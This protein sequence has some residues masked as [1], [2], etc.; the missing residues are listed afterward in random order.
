MDGDNQVGPRV[1]VKMRRR[2]FSVRRYRNAEPVEWVLPPGFYEN[3]AIGVWDES[4]VL[5]DRDP[6]VTQEKADPTLNK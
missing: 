2:L 4:G 1:P 6:L 5:V 3:P